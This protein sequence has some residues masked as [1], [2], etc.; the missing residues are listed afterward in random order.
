M[1]A[2]KIVRYIPNSLRKVT[3]NNTVE[4]GIP[5]GAFNN[6]T[7]LEE[8]VLNDKTNR[9]GEYAFTGCTN[10]VS[11]EIPDSVTG[12]APASLAGTSSLRCL[13]IPFMGTSAN[14]E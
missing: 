11:L 9:I 14:S 2:N 4:Y 10:I 13:K 5:Y 8:V 7:M 3:L 12:I 6:C 1:A